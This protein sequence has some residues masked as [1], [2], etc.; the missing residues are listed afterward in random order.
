MALDV[1]AASDIRAADAGQGL[2]FSQD[3]FLEFSR[4]GGVIQLDHHVPLLTTPVSG[5]T[6]FSFCFSPGMTARTK[7]KTTTA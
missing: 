3:Y 6:D 1:V 4:K 2:T 7:S 5:R